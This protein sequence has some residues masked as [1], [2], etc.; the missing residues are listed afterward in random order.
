[1][2]YAHV[3]F[4]FTI[5]T[6]KPVLDYGISNHIMNK[7][8]GEPIISSENIGTAVLLITFAM[9]GLSGKIKE[10]YLKIRVKYNQG[11]IDP[12]TKG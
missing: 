11:A 1:V 3:E 9:M 7:G 8:M 2:T 5:E 12:K 4:M 10:S 6:I